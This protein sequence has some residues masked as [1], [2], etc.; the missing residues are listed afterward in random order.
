MATIDELL[1]QYD[2]ESSSSNEASVDYGNE[3]YSGGETYQSNSSEE[4][5]SSNEPEKS[6]KSIDDLLNEYNTHSEQQA[7]QQANGGQSY[8]QTAVQDVTGQPAQQQKPGLFEKPEIKTTPERDALIEEYNN[9]GNPN[10]LHTKAERDAYIQKHD[11]LLG[12]LRAIDEELGNGAM[13]YNFRD[14]S[15]SVLGGSLK[16]YG[17][18]MMNAGATVLSGFNELGERLGGDTGQYAGWA[19]DEV[20]RAAIPQEN[21]PDAYAQQRQEVADMQAKSD[22]LAQASAADLERAKNNQSKFAQFGTDIATNAIQMGMDALAAGLTGGSSLAPMFVRSAGG[23]AREA[24]QDGASTA[25]QLTYGAVRGG[26]EVATE[27]MFDGLAKIYGAGFADDAIE[28]LIGKLGQGNKLVQSGLRWMFSGLGEAAEE[29]V[30]GLSEPLTKMI[31]QGI[32]ALKEYK[33]PEYWA[34][35]MYG[36]LVG[37]AMGGAGGAVNLVNGEN[38]KAN[39][40]IQKGID[41]RNEIKNNLIENNGMSEEDATK[42]SEILAKIANGEKIN[43]KQKAF[44]DTLQE[45]NGIDTSKPDVS[46][47]QAE[48]ENTVPVPDSRKFVREDATDTTDE[49]P[50][51]QPVAEMPEEQPAS[52]PEPKNPTIPETPQESPETPSG[53]LNS[54]PE[55]EGPTAEELEAAE[56]E[57]NAP[58]EAPPKGW[59]KTL[60]DAQQKTEDAQKKAAQQPAPEQPKPLRKIKPYTE[61]E[62]IL[63]EDRKRLDRENKSLRNRVDK[64]S[65]QTKRTDVKTARESDVRN[66]AKEIVKA[67]NSDVDIGETTV[68]MQALADYLVQHTGETIDYDTVQRMAEEIATDIVDNIFTNKTDAYS[69]ERAAAV[70]KYIKNNTVNVTQLLSKNYT[71]EDAKSDFPGMKFAKTKGMTV[72]KF[73]ELLT[74]EHLVEPDV[75]G[76]HDQLMKVYDAIYSGEDNIVPTYENDAN[77][78]QAVNETTNEILDTLLSDAV[79]ESE[80]TFADKQAAKLDATKARMQQQID[81]EKEA[82]KADRQAS[83]ER[84][85]QFR[86]QAA[87]EK[88]AA[89]EKERA[90]KYKKLDR[91]QEQVKNR[92]ERD[93]N[94]RKTSKQRAEIKKLAKDL[95]GRITR[96]SEG[97]Y[98]PAEF[99]DTAIE[100]LQ[101]IDMDTGSISSAEKVNSLNAKFNEIKEMPEYSGVFDSTHQQMLDNLAQI[102]DGT[103][104]RDMNADQLDAVIEAIQTLTKEIKN[105][106]KSKITGEERA[107]SETSKEIIDEINNAKSFGKG[108]MRELNSW[109]TLN[110]GRATTVFERLAGFKKDSTLSK[111]GQQLNDGQR[112]ATEEKVKAAK[113]FA[114]LLSDKKSSTLRDTVKLGKDASGKDIEVSRGMMLSLKMLLD[115]KAGVTHILNGGF[116]IPGISDY[117]KNKNDAGFGTSMGRALGISPELT[118]ARKELAELKSEYKKIDSETDK[119]N[120]DWENRIDRI[121]SEIDAKEAEIKAIEEKGSEFID[122]LKSEIEKQL[123]DYDKKWIKTAREYFDEVQ[124]SLNKTTFDVYGFKKANVENYFPILTDPN[125]RKAAFDSI[126]RDM[127]LENSGFMKARTNGANPLLLTDISEVIGRYAD[128]S[129]KYIGLMP[130]IR[131]FNKVYGKS[132][133]GYSDSVQHALNTKFGTGAAKYI[134]NLIGD[135]Q[136]VKKGSDDGLGKII[137]KARGNMAAA[138]LTLNPRVAFSQSASYLNAASEIGWEPLAKAFSMGTN[139][140]KDAKVMDLISKYTPLEYFRTLGNASADFG[141]IKNESLMMNRVNKKLDFLTGWIT[142]V[143]TRTVGRLWYASEAY[144]QQQGTDY[145]KGTDEYYEEVAKVFNR[146]VE[147]TQPNYTAMQRAGILRSSNE[148]VKSMT[149]F[150]TQRLQNQNIL[151]EAAERLNKYNADFKSGKNGVTEADVKK[152]RTDLGRAVTSQIASTAS[153]V[154]MKAVI[155]AVMH[156][157]KGYRDEDKELNKKG[158]GTKLWNM[159]LD[160][161]IG[162]FLGGQEL[163]GLYSGLFKGARYDGISVSGVTTISDIAKDLIAAANAKPE[164]QLEK[165]WKLV[166]DVSKVFGIPLENAEKFVDAV[167]KHGADIANGQFGTFESDL[168]EGPIDKMTKVDFGYQPVTNM[169]SPLYNAITQ[170]STSKDV[171][172]EI[173]RLYESTGI[174]GVYPNIRGVNKIS[175]DGEDYDLTGKEGQKYHE[176]AGKS[177]E[178][179]AKNLMDSKA[180]KAMSDDQKVQALKTLYSYA[181]DLA[182]DE[183]IADHGIKTDTVTTATSLLKGLDKAG[184]SND[185][186]ALNEKN[187]ADYVS[188][189][190]L[191]KSNINDGNYKDIDKLVSWYDGMDGNMKTV[192]KERNT[193]LKRLLEYKDVGEGSESYFKM[194]ESIIKSQINLDQNAN[195]SAYVRLYAVADCDLPE[196]SK[197]NIVRNLMQGD[198]NFIS[199]AGRTAFNTLS[200]YGMTVAQVAQFFDIAMHCASYKDTGDDKDFK[201][202]LTPENTAYALSQVPWFNDSQRTAIYNKIKAE[203][204]NDYKVN[205]W[206]NYT[207]A[208]EVKWFTNAKNK[209]TYGT[210]VQILDKREYQTTNALWNA[211][212]GNAS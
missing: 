56:R 16:G 168:S 147:K 97:K 89:V 37:Y 131:E 163:Y 176:T 96:P 52:N 99:M 117:Y 19:T 81:A 202:K 197:R 5:T 95:S 179:F 26:I 43:Q 152:A 12:Q 204:D 17:A 192:L 159:F 79:R 112:K 162:N 125:F 41:Q 198:D 186:T 58:E 74:E 127:S 173:Q 30:S 196:S 6:A 107:A 210:D 23:G 105:E 94:N 205:D 208:S 70:K 65:K 91:Y 133:A 120:R 22:E 104:L 129:S 32:D 29:G 109:Y 20:S 3:D 42:A 191:L 119:A 151:Y 172:K 36:M 102:V 46:A 160:S 13:D 144:V 209:A 154:T 139:P 128:N 90:D 53:E 62:K 49:F 44:L 126:Q 45:A 156:N 124:Q 82:R 9:L 193:D 146:V 10:Y 115:S 25:E 182:K 78:D 113:K 148:I 145:A 35:N 110:F 69:K 212:V 170:T 118:Q 24:R 180:Y 27:K 114:S 106:V 67:H 164:K 155:D 1:E 83:R 21:N 14:R 199:K 138:V 40:E 184:T 185:K 194:K 201:G 150:M 134:E 92:A 190:T 48:V 87:E 47:P 68:K 103:N 7:A 169:F 64:L 59:E 60:R 88:K 39:A 11:E 55:A 85:Q 207:Y 141:D 211:Y 143:D 51:E 108:F 135:L 75:S 100:L 183:F 66:A 158:V 177:A 8:V 93:A 50:A 72:Q 140:M 98:V 130:V 77:Y 122:S 195:T 54:E 149:M 76:A 73:Y 175:V 4:S 63:A 123:T 71:L 28:K 18:D 178:Q 157:L 80:P 111:V 161:M 206:G 167:W 142:A 86:K 189:T 31:Y 101:S 132:Q 171:A 166:E 116:T 33:D 121:V 165:T 84:L 15:Q 136:G 2:A 200:E 181:K 174:A 61:N 153:L 187:L 57:A 188:Y 137:G 38:R 203:S 34:E